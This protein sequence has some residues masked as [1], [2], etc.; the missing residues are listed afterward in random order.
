[1]KDELSTVSS[2]FLVALQVSIFSGV[3]V[4]FIGSVPQATSSTSNHRSS[5]SSSS[6]LSPIP[7]ASK[8]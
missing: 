1:M 5:S 8:S 3:L 7:S 2:L 6:S 4:A